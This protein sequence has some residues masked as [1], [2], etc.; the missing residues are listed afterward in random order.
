MLKTLK[1]VFVF[2]LL[3]PLANAQDLRLFDDFPYSYLPVQ[4]ANDSTIIHTSI[5]SRYPFY[6]NKELWKSSR[7]GKRNIWQWLNDKAF[8]E[9]MVVVKQPAFYLTVDPLVDFETGRELMSGKS[10]WVN[11]RG[12]Q[13]FGM[14]GNLSLCHT[15]AFL[16]PLN[17]A[18]AGTEKN[19]SKHR[20]LFTFYSRLFESQAVF[21]PYLDS[22]TRRL[23]VVPGQ[24]MQAIRGDVVDHGYSEAWI[25]YQPNRIFSF[26]AGHGQNF[27]GD[28][29][30]S[31]ILSDVARAYPYF[32]IDT[33]IWRIHYVNIWAE[34]QDI[35]YR[36]SYE[37]GYQKKYGAF[38]YFSIEVTRRMQVSF[39][40]AIIAQGRD[41]TH[42]RGF[43]INY[44]NPII[45]FRPLEWTMGS[46]DNALMGMNVN[47]RIGK[48]WWVYGQLMLDEFKLSHIKAWDGW[49]GNK[50]GGQ[51]GI[52]GRIHLTRNPQ[53][54][55]RNMQRFLF[56]RSE[57]NAARPYM[58]AHKTSK[59]NYG[60]W[61][62][63]LA[64]PL[65]ANFMEWV[66]FIR[67]R[68][69]HLAVEGRYSR[70]KFGSDYDGLNW[71]SD[72]YKS[73]ETYV[74]E[75]GNYIGQGLENILTYK[76]LTVSY[77]LNPFTNL[78]LFAKIIDRH[79]ITPGHD[80]HDLWFT[81]GL[82]SSVRNLYYD[83]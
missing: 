23:R 80:K 82:R 1:L 12:A 56:F 3:S 63:S 28:G 21:P 70:A 39:F 37:D 22:I 78:N 33:R 46:P 65:G 11:T 7:V 16:Q 43:E 18:K 4:Q 77:L 42:L 48:S 72:I 47:Y 67:F 52:K 29:Y 24:G 60:H 41:S 68:W 50:Q 66:N 27:L 44:L 69:D 20:G 51:L 79:Q 59:Q 13:A 15:S 17:P 75:F 61:N 45:F 30:R 26:E 64:H 10:T 25:R 36:N 81:L 5:R 35:N 38:H 83:F 76:I 54:A 74:N 34:H 31:L 9:P 32:R 58:Y 62:Q 6:E 55:T 71:G 57:F 40:E 14:I 8:H 49:W 19:E 2:F 73:Y 53:S